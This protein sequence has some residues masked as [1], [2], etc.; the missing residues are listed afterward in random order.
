MKRM[1][2]GF[3]LLMLTQS[4][5]AEIEEQ[6]DVGIM[7]VW[8]KV[9][10]S[11]GDPVSDLKSEEFQLY[12]DDKKVELRC[13]DRTFVEP[14]SAATEAPRRK[15]VFFFDLYNTLPGD[16]EFLKNSITK[17]I[18]D[19]FHSN[20]QG[21]IFALLP[22]V[23]LGVVQKMTDNR[24]ALISVI[25][26]M[27]GNMSLGSTLENNE[28]QLLDL[29]YP[30]DTTSDGNNPLAGRGVGTRP[31]EYLRT[32]QAMAR[33]LAAQE[34][35]RS[36]I[37]LNS[38]ISV[39]QYLSEYSLDGSVALIYV[40]G[41]FPMQPGEHY[42]ALVERTIEE[43][44][45][46]D[47]TYLMMMERP[48]VNF[49]HDVKRTIGKL[50]RMN[51]TIYS[52]DAKGLL[53]N[54]RGAER[55]SVQAMRGMNVLSRNHQLQ[56]SLVVIANETGGVAFV[57]GQNYRKGLEEIVRD[58]NE[59]YLLCGT[60]QPSSKRGEYHEIDVKVTRPGVKVR[61]RKGYVD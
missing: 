27:K 53:M 43:R 37:T 6:V 19:S 11:N 49:Q 17:F 58:M 22:S 51:V 46:V 20:D 12:I 7:E 28:R 38:F 14:T 1:A 29:L 47:S 59:Q 30:F 16:M 45:T 9:T 54:A 36:R 40:S 32:A 35:N 39:G 48:R 23:H 26:K 52:L 50:N 13:F 4:A 56:D 10:D 18:Q 61:H 44:F 33:N 60:L 34:E 25:R 8:V 15:F 21:M 55:D 42:F 24:Q 2:L 41:G 5:L 31:N 3:L 57:N